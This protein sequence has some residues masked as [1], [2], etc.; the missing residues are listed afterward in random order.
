[1]VQMTSLIIQAPYQLIG[2]APIQNASGLC[3][4][5]LFKLSFSYRLVEGVATSAGSSTFRSLRCLDSSRGCS[6]WQPS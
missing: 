3:R 5:G 2:L 4:S 6:P 1:M